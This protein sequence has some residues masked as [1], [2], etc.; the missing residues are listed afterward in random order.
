MMRGNTMATLTTPDIAAIRSQFPALA[1]GFA[2]LENAGG[3]QLPRV[4]VEAMTQFLQESYCQTGSS[5]PASERAT[6]TFRGARDFVNALFNGENLGFPVLGPS[7]TALFNMLAQCLAPRLQPGDE[8]ICMESSHESHIGPWVRLQDRGI[9][10]RWWRVDPQTG[11]SDIEDL[12]NLLTDRTK[13]V[14]ATMT[15]NLVGDIID[16]KRVAELARAAGAVTVVDAVAAASHQALNVADWG[17]DFCAFSHYKVYGP[18]MAALWGRSERWAELEGLNHFFIPASVG[19][20]KFELG[21]QNYEGC[22]GIL[23]LEAYLQFLAP[24]Q[25][26]RRATIEAAFAT[27]RAC[28]E[29]VLARLMDYLAARPELR[30]LGETRDLSRRHPTVSFVSPKRTP[31]EVADRVHL[32]PIGIKTGHMYAYRLCQALGLD[33]DSGV[34]RVSAVHYNTVE[35]IDRLCTALDDVLE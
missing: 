14:A 6:T 31:A 26:N 21:C 2:F 12:K 30:V 27:M 13:V 28:E 4:V 32:E 8:I 17:V 33:P 24:D 22:A 18:H 9:V 1:G 35:E 11:L 5:Y 29:P 23:A 10:V 20:N 15:S 16:V 7:T 25:P 34:V 19:G 3:S